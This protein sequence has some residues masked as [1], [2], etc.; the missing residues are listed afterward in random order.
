MLAV[1]YIQC[2]FSCKRKELQEIGSFPEREIPIPVQPKQ[3]RLLSLISK[4]ITYVK[5]SN[6]SC[7]SSQSHSLFSS[8]LGYWQ[9]LTQVTITV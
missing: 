4:E 7:G 1:C 5:V 8:K 9:Q 2:A 6:D 3:T